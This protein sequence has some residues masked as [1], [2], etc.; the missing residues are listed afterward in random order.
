MK[1]GF[2]VSHEFVEFI[3]DNLRSRTLY[4]SIPYATAAHL[5]A[6]GCGEKVVTPISRIGWSV[7][8]DGESV[9]LHP[10]V[11][12]FGLRCESHYF[13]RNGRIVWA[14]KMSSEDIRLGRIRD[15]ML[16]QDDSS[17]DEP[18]SGSPARRRKWFDW[19]FGS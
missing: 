19:L 15:G 6:C 16:P 7:T 10:S 8:Y 9:S 1:K 4:V 14:A 3:P 2:P 13:I 5:C 18:N 12:N 17:A 11:G